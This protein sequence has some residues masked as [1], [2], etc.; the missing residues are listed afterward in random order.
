MA[1]KISNPNTVMGASGNAHAPGTV[2]DP[3]ATAGTARFLREDATFIQASFGNIT[4]TVAASQ[5]P[6]P[7]SST[8]GG[9]ES[10]AAV[11]NN[12]MTGISTSGVPTYSQ[13][14]FTNLS[15][16][17]AA[18]QMPAFTGDVTTTAGTTATTAKGINGTILSGLSTGLLKITTGTGAPSI[19]VAGTDFAGIGSTNTYS[20][21]QTFSAGFVTPLSSSSAPATGGTIAVTSPVANV[22]PTAAITGVILASGTTTGQ[23][24]TVLNNSTFSITFAASG[25]SHVA[26]GVSDVIAAD[27]ARDFIWNGS[28]WFRKG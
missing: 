23:I 5:L 24:V 10:L 21:V 14:S 8:L 18:A 28:L 7:T 27:T 16:S 9:V 26:D 25:T 3:G 20:S 15:G 17:V 19:A 13:P 12:F 1:T 6:N 11:A 2:P 22:A 4:G